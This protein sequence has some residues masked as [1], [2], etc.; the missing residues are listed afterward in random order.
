MKGNEISLNLAMCL[1]L[2]M[3]KE[4]PDLADDTELCLQYLQK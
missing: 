3:V 4:E 2:Q 1:N